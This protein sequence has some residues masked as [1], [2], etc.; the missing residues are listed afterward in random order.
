[1]QDETQRLLRDLHSITNNFS[2]QGD[3]VAGSLEE[4]YLIDPTTNSNG[5]TDIPEGPEG[6]E[7]PD[8]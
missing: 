1:M 4:G 7:G 2:I 3:G 5:P 6:P 8:Q